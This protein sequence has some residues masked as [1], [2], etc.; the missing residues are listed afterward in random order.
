MLA[1]CSGNTQQNNQDTFLELLKLQPDTAI[2][3]ADTGHAYIVMNDFAKVRDEYGI[4]L[5]SSNDESD[6]ENY[7][8]SIFNADHSLGTAGP[9][10]D[11]TWGSGFNIAYLQLHTYSIRS[12]NVG[13]GPNNVNASIESETGLGLIG[14]FDPQAAQTD[15]NGQIGWSKWAKDDFATENYQ[16]VTINSWGD[17]TAVHLLDTSSPP[18]TDELGRA[19]PLA[20]TPANVYFSDTTVNIK[21]M[22][23]ANMGK[24]TSMADDPK[25]TSI[26]KGLTEL[27]AYSAIISNDIS[28]LG[29]VDMSSLKASDTG[30]APLLQPYL[31]LGSGEGKDDNG[32]YL[33]LVLVYNN[34]KSATANEEILKARIDQLKGTGTLDS[35]ISVEDNMIL[36]KLYVPGMT[37][38]M[39][40]DTWPFEN[41]VLLHQ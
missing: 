4:S 27:G 18:D 29:L 5:P 39:S 8:M 25:Y 26:A 22:I 10:Y 33:A 20:V 21:S 15:F 41:T 35:Q 7:T 40:A 16:N 13:Y 14:K 38:R 24:S 6:I 37:N 19:H 32:L 30:T 12:N 11:Y 9:G 2:T 17:G 31:A 34:N 36:G 3:T 1:G 23:D 28:S